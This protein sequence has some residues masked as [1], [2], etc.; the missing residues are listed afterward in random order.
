MTALALASLLGATVSTP[1]AAAESYEN[2]AGFIDSLPATISKPGTWCLRKNLSTSIA[3]GNA[4]SITQ[5]HVNLDCNGFQIDGLAAGPSADTR[6]I[7]VHHAT[8]TV[9]RNCS[10]R[11]FRYGIELVGG[12]TNLIEDNLFQQNFQIG[13]KSYFAGSLVRR[14]RVIDT[15]GRPD[16]SYS[17]GI[18]TQ[19]DVVDNTVDG[20]FAAL[21]GDLEGI[22]VFSDRA[23]LIRGNRVRNFVLNGG[24]H[25]TAIVSFTESG[26]HLVIRNQ[27]A[28]SPTIKG[29]FVYIS[30]Y[31]PYC[32]G[33]D[34]AGLNGGLGYFC[35]AEFDN[36]VH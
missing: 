3:S 10:V 9:V 11:G 19:G 34:V 17:A 26:N 23:A 16:A 36:I 15:G 18:F 32:R 6:G 31:P 27:V 24:G 25:A 35:L 21:P 1:V 13:I 14:N 28:N 22:H 30:V 5:S 8:Y 4:L 20:I 12:Q 33:N 2:C 7:Y 29:G